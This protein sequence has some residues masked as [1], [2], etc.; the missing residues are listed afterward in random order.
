MVERDA[1]LRRYFSLERS[2]WAWSSG[3]WPRPRP[4]ARGD[5]AL[6]IVAGAVDRGFDVRPC[7]RPAAIAEASVQP[8]P[9]VWRVSIREAL[10]DADARRGSPAR[11]TRSRPARCPPLTSTAR[12]PSASSASPAARIA[13]DDRRSS[14]PHRISASGRFGV[15]TAARGDQQPLQRV[16]RVGLDQRRA[17]LRDHH[18]VD[19]QRDLPARA[20]AS[21]AATVSITAASC[22]MPVLTASAPIS[23]STTSICWRMKSGGIGEHAEN[24]LGVLRGQRSDR[25]RRIGV[26]HR[27]RLDVG[28]DTGAAARIRPGDD[29][30]P[31]LHYSAASSGAAAGFADRRANLADDELIKSSFSPFGHDANGNFRA[32]FA[33]DQTPR[34][35]EPRLVGRDRCA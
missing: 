32:G 11:R 16:D 22:S 15:S 29:Q 28:L 35:A 10:P 26:E 6:D 20:P 23:S 4:G 5:R 25:R 9:W 3:P 18:R 19:D 30:D 34:R 21:T 33:D 13:G 31:A 8:V 7:A 17:A 2:G 27:H 1:H 24:A 12:Q 14:R